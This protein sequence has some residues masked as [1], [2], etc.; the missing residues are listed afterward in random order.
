MHLCQGFHSFNKLFCIQVELIR[1]NKMD[2]ASLSIGGQVSGILKHVDGGVTVPVKDGK[3]ILH[4][5][6]VGVSGLKLGKT[7][8]SRGSS[9]KSYTFLASPDQ[10]RTLLLT[11]NDDDNLHLLSASPDI[12]NTILNFDCR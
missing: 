7:I 3:E 4:L 5:E 8:Y 12:S 11:A 10:S 6:Y 2:R 1:L 9:I